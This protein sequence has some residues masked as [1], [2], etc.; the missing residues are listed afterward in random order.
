M[1]VPEKKSKKRPAHENPGKKQKKKK[2]KMD[3]IQE[4]KEADIFE[5]VNR[6]ENSENS[7]EED[8]KTKGAKGE[9]NLGLEALIGLHNDQTNYTPNE[10][11][12]DKKINLSN[13]RKKEKQLKEKQLKI[14]MTVP[15]WMKH[16]VLVE[17]EVRG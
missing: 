12:S 13:L 2:S 9:T 14:D 1:I 4:C 5:S 10:M 7:S 11:E 6:E 17:E 15:R 8:K 3:Q 16:G